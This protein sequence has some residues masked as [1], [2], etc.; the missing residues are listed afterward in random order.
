MP[1][2]SHEQRRLDHRGRSFLFVSYDSEDR[3]KRSVEPPRGPTWYLV[4]ANHRWP[5]VPYRSGQNIEEVDALCIA[6]LEEVVFASV[7][8]VPAAPEPAQ[9]FLRP[10]HDRRG[11]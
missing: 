6:W 8:A 2:L 3:P 1:S 7:A 11:A 9:R 4:S 5:A 10:G